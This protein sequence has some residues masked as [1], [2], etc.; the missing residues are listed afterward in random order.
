M[1]VTERVRYGAG[2]AEFKSQL[3]HLLAV[4]GNNDSIHFKNLW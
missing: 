3:Y 1:V 2:Q 4:L